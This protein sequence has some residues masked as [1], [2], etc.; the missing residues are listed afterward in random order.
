MQFG[1]HQPARSYYVQ[2]D[3][4]TPGGKYRAH[5]DQS[6]PDIPSVALTHE[7]L[8]FLFDYGNDA[9]PEQIYYR[10]PMQDSGKW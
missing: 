10:C 8:D 3:E 1:A 2:L 6:G 7:G 5:I 4:I 9:D